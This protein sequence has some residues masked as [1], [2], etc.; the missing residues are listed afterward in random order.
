MTSGGHEHVAEQVD[1]R[2]LEGLGQPDEGVDRRDRTVRPTV[3][4]PLERD[5]VG[6][7]EAGAPGDVAGGAAERV[8]SFD[9][10]P[11]EGR[12]VE[13]VRRPGSV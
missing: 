11:G 9:D 6:L 3:A 8:T 12:A 2:Q 7:G 5:D 10:H 13:D 4:R 1:G